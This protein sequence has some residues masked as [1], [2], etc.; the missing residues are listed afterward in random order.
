MA[1]VQI[2][3][4]WATCLGTQGVCEGIGVSVFQLVDVL[5]MILI[6]AMLVERQW[7]GDRDPLR[8]EKQPLLE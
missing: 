4:T 5:L 3:L 2:L 6:Q 8:K 7:A 1:P